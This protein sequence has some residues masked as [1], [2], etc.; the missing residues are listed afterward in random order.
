M[1]IIRNLSRKSVFLFISLVI[2]SIFT[3]VVLLNL[4]FLIEI[5]RKKGTSFQ[6][7]FWSINFLFEL[8]VLLGIGC[9]LLVLW[10]RL[11]SEKRRTLEPNYKRIF[12][13]ILL[14]GGLILLIFIPLTIIFSTIPFGFVF[15]TILRIGII[16][17]MFGW[18]MLLADKIEKQ[19]MET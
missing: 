5:I 17:Y 4:Y 12:Q 18:S 16:L 2:I 8:F 19:K 6:V 3:L 10:N 1:K 13:I 7:Q 15:N 11:F 14:I 9:F